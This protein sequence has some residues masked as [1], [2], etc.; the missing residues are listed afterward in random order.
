M[1]TRK[2]RGS[3]RYLKICL[4]VKALIE[5]QDF[6]LPTWFAHLGHDS[7]VMEHEEG[8]GVYLEGLGEAATSEI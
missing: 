3:L 7:I 2:L 5:D 8:R 1:V 6:F 4:Q